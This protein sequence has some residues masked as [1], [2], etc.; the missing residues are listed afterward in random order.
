[1]CRCK[2]HSVIFCF[3]IKTYFEHA[4]D[5]CIVTFKKINERVNFENLKSVVI[6]IESSEFGVVTSVIGV[7]ID[8][9]SY[10]SK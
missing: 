6:S 5:C 7:D 1:M 8:E 2:K 3:I 10:V 4:K 9:T